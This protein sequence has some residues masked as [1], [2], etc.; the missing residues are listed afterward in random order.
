MPWRQV[1]RERQEERKEGEE[2]DDNDNNRTL[3]L[4]ALFLYGLFKKRQ[5]AHWEP[6]SATEFLVDSPEF[7][8]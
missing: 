2:E 5:Q 1:D 4:A 8:A 6:C 3:P 7:E